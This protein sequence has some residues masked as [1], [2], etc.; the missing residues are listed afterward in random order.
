METFVI[1]FAFCDSSSFP[2]QP[3]NHVD[4]IS[5]LGFL[6]TDWCQQLLTKR[7]SGGL[8][9]FSAVELLDVMFYWM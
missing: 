8:E 1:N 2:I 4:C 9:H 3:L 7:R 5:V 6:R